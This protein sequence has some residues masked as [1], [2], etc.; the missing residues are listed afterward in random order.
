MY[1]ANSFLMDY[2]TVRKLIAVAVILLFIDYLIGVEIN[3]FV[4]IPQQTAFSFFGYTG[5]VEVLAHIATGIMIII[6]ALAMLA[7]S[8]KLNNAF[9]STLSLLA[10]AFIVGAAGDGALFL[11]LGQ[12]NTYSMTMAIGF[13]SAF[14]VY[15]FEVIEVGRPHVSKNFEARQ[16]G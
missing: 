10:L 4:A 6:V 8:I 14:I 1:K 3:L 15:F 12:Q 9:L 5:G 2:R 13:V 7:S 16:E 11:L